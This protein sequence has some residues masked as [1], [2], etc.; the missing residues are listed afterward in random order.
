M[1]HAPDDI[2]EQQL[3]GQHR[4]DAREP[5]SEIGVAEQ[6]GAE[7]DEPGDHRR[8]IEEAQH[9]LLRPGPVIGLVGTQFHQACV[10]QPQRRHRRDH[11][12]KRKPTPKGGTLRPG[13]ALIG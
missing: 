5:H 12:G 4:H 3:R 6:R 13:L 1:G 10:S 8:M 9:V 2:G 7:P 11:R